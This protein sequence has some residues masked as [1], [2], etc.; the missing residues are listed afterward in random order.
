M[1]RVGRSVLLPVVVSMSLSVGLVLGVVSPAVATQPAAG[2]SSKTSE[3]PSAVPPLPVIKSKSFDTEGAA[4]AASAPS[5]AGLPIV[6]QAPTKLISPTSS[7]FNPFVS[8]PI[9]HGTN[10]TLF[11][12][13][14]ARRRRKFRR[15][16]STFTDPMDHG[17]RPPQRSSRT[18]LRVPSASLTM[19]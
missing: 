2:A 8:T 9:S 13:P 4:N 12:I 3:S 19:H 15:R 7:A 1:I 17:F 5:H 14:M 16:R 11:A 6:P 18:R 10:D